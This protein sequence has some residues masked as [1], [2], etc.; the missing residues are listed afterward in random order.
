M[1][2]LRADLDVS[3]STDLATMD[4]SDASEIEHLKTFH[5]H[6]GSIGVAD[7]IHPTSMLSC[8]FIAATFVE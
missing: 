2:V 4:G 1:G 7:D 8:A 5:Q 3:D 6:C